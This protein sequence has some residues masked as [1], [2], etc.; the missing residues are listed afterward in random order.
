MGAPSKPTYLLWLQMLNKRSFTTIIQSN[1]N[2]SCFSA[3]EAQRV[4]NHFE[5]SHFENTSG[6]INSE[7]FVKREQYNQTRSIS[8][9][10]KQKVESRRR[11]T[12]VLKTLKTC[13]RKKLL[14]GVICANSPFDFGEMEMKILKKV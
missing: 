13:F 5:K 14:W 2:N 12:N 7:P 6:R 10:S 1:H 4:G 8:T 11:Q 9:Q 3:L